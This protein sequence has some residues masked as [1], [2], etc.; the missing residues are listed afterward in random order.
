MD[1]TLA[2]LTCGGKT[3]QQTWEGN[4]AIY[5]KKV[6]LEVKKHNL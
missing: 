2:T 3:I 6:I 4:L 1:I 5:E